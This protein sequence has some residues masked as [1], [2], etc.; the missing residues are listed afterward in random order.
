MTTGEHFKALVLMHRLFIGSTVVLLIVGFFKNLGASPIIADGEELG[1]LLE[2]FVIG[3]SLISI[4]LSIGLFKV[5]ISKN[6]KDSGLKAKLTV[7]RNAFILRLAI[8]EGAALFGFLV[9]FLTASMICA[10]L[11]SFVIAFMFLLRPSKEEVK[12]ELALSPEEE[13]ILTNDNARIN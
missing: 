10:T 1:Q 7:Y 8:L 2:Y 13:N 4:P 6:L 5:A 12:K 3:Y 11:A 9:F